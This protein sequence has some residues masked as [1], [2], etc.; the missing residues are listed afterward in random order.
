LLVAR[1]RTRAIIT[2]GTVAVYACAALLA[3]A[4]V[5]GPHGT[6]AAWAVFTR[7]VVVVAILVTIVFIIFIVHDTDPQ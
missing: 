4:V 2:L 3:D 5:Y 7:L 6:H 1:T